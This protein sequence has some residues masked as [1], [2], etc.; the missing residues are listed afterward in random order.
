MHRIKNRCAS[1]KKS[2]QIVSQ[3]GIKGPDTMA[4]LGWAKTNIYV[5]VLHNSVLALH[6]GLC[7]FA[8]QVASV[9]W[10]EIG[11]K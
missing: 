1:Y 4:N 3:H 5:Y 6:T 2:I 7:V 10:H 9:H 11:T 8:P